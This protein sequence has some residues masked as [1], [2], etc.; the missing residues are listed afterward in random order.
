MRIHSNN[1]IVVAEQN[2]FTCLS[3][4]VPPGGIATGLEVSMYSSNVDKIKSIVV[5]LEQSCT[6]HCPSSIALKEHWPQIE[7]PST[8]S[9]NTARPAVIST[10]A[11]SPYL[12]FHIKHD[13]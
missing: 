4:R 9:C 13:T 2:L 1:T 3:V 6:K 12:I 5:L 10:G 7:P 11:S 8:A